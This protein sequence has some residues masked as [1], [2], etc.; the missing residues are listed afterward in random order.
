MKKKLIMAVMAVMLTASAW[1][2]QHIFT[3]APNQSCMA[4]VEEFIVK[5][6][7][8]LQVAIPPKKQDNYIVTSFGAT[9][10]SKGYILHCFK[11]NNDNQQK[12]VVIEKDLA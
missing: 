12:L 4:V 7:L 1:A 10:G 5:S 2:E 6:K 3:L 11:F 8:E 9:S